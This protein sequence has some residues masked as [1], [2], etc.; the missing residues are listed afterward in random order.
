MN[1][2]VEFLGDRGMTKWRLFCKGR[3]KS[4]M[5]EMNMERINRTFKPASCSSYE[6]LLVKCQDA[7]AAWSGRRE[8]AWRLGLQG[9][10]LGAELVRLQANFAKAYAHLQ[11]HTRE[12]A[13]CEFVANFGTDAPL[14]ARSSTV[15]ETKPA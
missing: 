1:V 5:P 11:K 3:K 6:D 4:S 12:C 7:L 15:N 14:M 10:E 13:L 9:K 2:K 8:E